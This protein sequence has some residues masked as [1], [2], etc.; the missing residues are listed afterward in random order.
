MSTEAENL[1]RVLAGLLKGL[2]GG[3][4][5]HGGEGAQ[6]PPGGID[7]IE[8]DLRI[9]ITADKRDFRDIVQMRGAMTIQRTDPYM[10]KDGR[11]Q[12]DFK[13]LS[14]TATGWSDALMVALTYTL[15]RDIDQPTSTIVAQ[16][17]GHDY[18]ATFNF[19]VVFDALVNN[20]TVFRA[21]EGRPEGHGFY[22]VPPSGDRRLSP[23]ITRFTDLGAV[24]IGHPDLGTLLVKPIDCNDQHGETLKFLPGVKLVAPLRLSAA[25]A[26][27]SRKK[28]RA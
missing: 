24:K 19:R 16:Q 12:I 11:R 21:L 2:S 17:K 1:G 15:S 14:W 27:V 22:Q 5:G 10:T 26:T 8:H 25:P 3:R 7:F 9:L 13:V 18:P 23:T 6:F 20:A 28:R 4:G